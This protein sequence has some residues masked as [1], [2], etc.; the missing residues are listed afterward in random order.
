MTVVN[1]LAQ[2]FGWRSSEDFGAGGGVGGLGGG[3]FDCCAAVLSVV[4]VFFLL[5]NLML[6]TLR[7]V[8]LSPTR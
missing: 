3:R 4:C 6:P 8:F 7:G 5:A 1:S 2:T